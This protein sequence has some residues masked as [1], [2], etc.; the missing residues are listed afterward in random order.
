MM[1]IMMV[2]MMVVT[3]V[4]MVMMIMVMMV[5]N[6]LLFPTYFI[7][8]KLIRH[9]NKRIRTKINKRKQFNINHAY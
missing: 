9:L 5:S 8:S 3:G 4:M 2:V 7:A 1:V 6:F